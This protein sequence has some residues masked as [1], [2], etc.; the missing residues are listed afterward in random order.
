MTDEKT[1]RAQ[2]ALKDG[3]VWAPISQG[4]P[5]KFTEGEMAILV[6]EGRAHIKSPVDRPITAIAKRYAISLQQI[7][8][9]VAALRKG[10]VPFRTR[11]D[12]QQREPF[13][14]RVALRRKDEEVIAEKVEALE[15]KK[16]MK[17]QHPLVRVRDILLDTPRGKPIPEAAIHECL[18]VL[19]A[20][21]E[22]ENTLIKALQASRE[23][24][25]Q[26]GEG[27][28]LGPPPPLTDGEMVDCSVE[29]L[30]AIGMDNSIKA[31]R[32]AYGAY[33]TVTWKKLKEEGDK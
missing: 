12:P 23:V 3:R 19:A 18:T 20:T 33:V 1:A 24:A 11:P 6:E 5:S 2:Q 25:R 8:R 17:K 15:D 21:T 16:L 4:R 30:R 14:D 7:Q 13:V 10:E 32:K 9:V 29:E 22:T 28:H 31:L 26:T 27:T